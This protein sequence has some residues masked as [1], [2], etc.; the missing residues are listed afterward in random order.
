MSSGEHQGWRAAP[1]PP[2]TGA[3]IPIGELIGQGRA[4]WPGIRISEEEFRVFLGRTLPPAPVAPEV[5]GPMR[6]DELYLICAYARGDAGAERVI[7]DAYLPRVEAALARLP[8][9]LAPPLRLVILEGLRL[10]LR[11]GVTSP[12]GYV[13]RGD[14][15]GWLCVSAVREAGRMCGRPRR[16]GILGTPHLL[17]ERGPER[18]PEMSAL[19]RL[20]TDDFDSAYREALATLSSRERNLLRYRLEEELGLS[21]ISALFQIAPETVGRWLR[22]VRQR[23]ADRTRD[24]LLRRIGQSP[25][26]VDRA[27][28]QVEEQIDTLVLPAPKE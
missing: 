9:P 22:E 4:A 10:R 17:F 5:S 12:A 16:E 1:L 25:S 18:D 19:R 26:V 23:L 13:G 6:A 11:E 3:E 20:Y 27:L 7:E 28:S 15:L 21:Q 24:R 8:D 14:L 2:G